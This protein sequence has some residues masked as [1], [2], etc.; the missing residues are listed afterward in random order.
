MLVI[1]DLHMGGGGPADDF[2]ADDAVLRYLDRAAKCDEPLILAGDVLELWQFSE[3]EIQEAHPEV[4]A[5]LKAQ[6]KVII[7]GNHD[8]R[9]VLFGRE[10]VEHH[11]YFIRP[12]KRLWSNFVVRI[13]HGHRFDPWNH[14]LLEPVGQGAA[15]AAGQLERLVDRDADIWLSNVWH[16]L[17]NTGRY[18]ETQKYKDKGLAW[19]AAEQYSAIILG[20]THKFAWMPPYFNAGSWVTGASCGS[21]SLKGVAECLRQRI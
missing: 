14:G 12:A 15:W 9:P 16:S 20:H 21:I 19:C 3:A 8:D 1:S 18:A 17:T 13:E 11:D 10:T 6:A 5:R 2:W 7:R 4:Y